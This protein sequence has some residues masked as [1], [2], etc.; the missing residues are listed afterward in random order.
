MYTKHTPDYY[1]CGNCGRDLKVSEYS[2]YCSPDIKA[3]RSDVHVH[4]SPNYY[5]FTL[6]CTCGNYTVVTDVKPS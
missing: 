5:P 1:P 3:K 4:Y 2:S 6:M